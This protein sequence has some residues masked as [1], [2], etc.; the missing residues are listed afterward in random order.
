MKIFI[1][2]FHF[3]F[4]VKLDRHGFRVNVKEFWIL[5]VTREKAKYFCVNEFY[6]GA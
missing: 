2:E 1:R 6:K 4:Y 3:Y 5:F